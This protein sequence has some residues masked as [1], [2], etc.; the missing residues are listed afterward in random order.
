MCY[1]HTCIS[2][3]YSAGQYIALGT[4]YYAH[5]TI[6]IGSVNCFNSPFGF[7]YGVINMRCII[8]WI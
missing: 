4:M 6:S 7:V 2:L 1:I 8:Y 5:D 3:V